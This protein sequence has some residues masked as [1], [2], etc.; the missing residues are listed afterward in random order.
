M[1]WIRPVAAAA[2]SVLFPGAGHAFIRDW[3]R[4]LLFGGLFVTVLAVF[5]PTGDI[6]TAASFSDAAAV[7]IEDSSS[8]TRFLLSFL[9]L[10]AAIDSTFRAAGLPPGSG[11]DGDG[12]TCPRCGRELDEDLEFCHWCTTELDSDTGLAAEEP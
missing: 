10:F 1:T 12:P 7:A 2:L 4:A 8:T 6:A 5:L 9:V 11:R 3:V